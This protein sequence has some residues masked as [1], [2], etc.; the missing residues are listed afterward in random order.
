MSTDVASKE[1][2]K[3]EFKCLYGG[4]CNKASPYSMEI[5]ISSKDFSTSL[6]SD[7]LHKERSFARFP[8][9]EGHQSIYRR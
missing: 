5:E 3:A 9:D 6:R 2:G 7:Q 8:D 4:P 1:G